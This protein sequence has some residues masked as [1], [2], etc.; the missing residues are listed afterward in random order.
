[1]TVSRQTAWLLAAAALLLLAFAFDLGGYALLEPDEGRNAEVAREMAESNDYVVPTLNG[2]PYLD[3]PAL[4]FV[5]GASL[6]EVLGPTELAARLPSLL[7]T[8]GTLALVFWF[9]MR[10]SGYLRAE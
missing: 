10:M 4:Y 7:F 5:V 9:G 6:M 2:L 1:M 3:K 8:L